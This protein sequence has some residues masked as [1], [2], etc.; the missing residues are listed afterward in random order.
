MRKLTEE[1]K[2]TLA[3]LALAA[4]MSSCT[5]TVGSETVTITGCSAF[6]MIYPSRADTTETKRQIL[7]HNLTYKEVCNEDEKITQTP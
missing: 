5:N 6:G 2:K 3:V 4:S 1:M 7:A